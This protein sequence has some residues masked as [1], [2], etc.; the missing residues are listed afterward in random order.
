MG[1]LC[2]KLDLLDARRGGGRQGPASREL[3]PLQ[4]WTSGASMATCLIEGLQRELPGAE[5]T[6]SFL[7][8]S[9]KE[10][11]LGLFFLCSHTRHT[12]PKLS[13]PIQVA[14]SNRATEKSQHCLLVAISWLCRAASLPVPPSRDQFR[15]GK[16][17]ASLCSSASKSDGRRKRGSATETKC[18]SAQHPCLTFT[19]TG[20]ATGPTPHSGSVPSRPVLSPIQNPLSV[21]AWDLSLMGSYESHSPCG[22]H[23]ENSIRD[24]FF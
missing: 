18:G 6:A 11:Q 16:G 4:P 5:D 14:P 3:V 13:P 20:G 19:G 23:Q 15:E 1:Q 21:R 2:W 7:R 10:A 24:F 22:S 9:L 17:D 8:K 12:S